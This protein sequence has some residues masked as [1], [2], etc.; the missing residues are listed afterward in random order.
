MHCVRAT[1]NNSSDRATI[2]S[3]TAERMGRRS[4]QIVVL[5]HWASVESEKKKG[6]SVELTVSTSGHLDHMMRIN[7]T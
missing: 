6:E 3:G 5:L 4:A 1:E 2:G 7:K